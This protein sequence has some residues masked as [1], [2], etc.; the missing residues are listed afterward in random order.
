MSNFD[1]IEAKFELKLGEK[2]E[3]YQRTI[4]ADAG[5]L[6]QSWVDAGLIEAPGGDS[7]WG[8]ELLVEAELHYEPRVWPL[9]QD[10]IYMAATDLFSES[11]NTN[12]TQPRMEDYHEGDSTRP[13]E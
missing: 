12:S 13:T 7:D 11:V 9:A 8:P 1:E 6:A 5:K 3:Y 4:I 2:S 10:Y